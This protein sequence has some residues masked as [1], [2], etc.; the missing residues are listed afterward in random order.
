M[1]K[2]QDYGSYTYGVHAW[3]WFD[4]EDL[5]FGTAFHDN[6]EGGRGDDVIYGGDGDDDISDAT[7]TMYYATPASLFNDYSAAVARKGNRL[8]RSIRPDRS[9]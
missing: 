2:V 5:I 6:L 3:G 7:I 1:T 8:T 9:R 4:D